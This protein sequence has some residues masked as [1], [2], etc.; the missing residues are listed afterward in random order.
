[1]FP[2]DL[3]Q[4]GADHYTFEVQGAVI[5]HH[6]AGLTAVKLHLFLITSNSNM[7]LRSGET[8][9]SFFAPSGTSNT[10]RAFPGGVGADRAFQVLCS[11][12]SFCVVICA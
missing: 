11:P 8:K 1:M 3:E 12:A 9:T 6:M 5:L 4:L 10:F 7:V 2:A